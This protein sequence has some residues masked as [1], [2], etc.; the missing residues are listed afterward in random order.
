MSAKIQGYSIAIVKDKDI[1]KINRKW[2]KIQEN[3]LSEDLKL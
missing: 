1:V 2:L 3:V